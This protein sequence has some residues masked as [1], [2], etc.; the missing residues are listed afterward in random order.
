M[1]SLCAKW[2]PARVKGIRVTFAYIL[3]WEKQMTPL[4]PTF[5]GQTAPD[6]CY[7]I[8]RWTGYM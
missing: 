1:E 5:I 4:M 3:E 2:K 8:F 6:R 7:G